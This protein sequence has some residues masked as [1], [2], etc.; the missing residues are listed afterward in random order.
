MRTRLVLVALAL[1]ATGAAAAEV[2]RPRVVDLDAPGAL[3]ALARANPGHFEAVRR[4]LE[5]IRQRKDAEVPRWLQVSFGARDV[6]WVPMLLTSDPPRR[7][8]SFALDGT[9]Y[10]AVLTLTDVRGRIIPLR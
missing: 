6:S 2:P 4:I 7:R 10:E 3:E 8:L 5:G 9:R 1:L